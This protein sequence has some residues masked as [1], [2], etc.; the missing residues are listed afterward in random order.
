MVS[1]GASAFCP[2]PLV[3]EPNGMEELAQQSPVGYSTTHLLQ[4]AKAVVKGDAK[5]ST[6]YRIWAIDYPD[7]SVSLSKR[8]VADCQIQ[9]FLCLK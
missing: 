3:A 5:Q 1:I 7:E 2:A 9:L 8:T 4:L 6:E